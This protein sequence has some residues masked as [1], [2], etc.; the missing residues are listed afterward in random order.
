MTPIPPAV[1]DPRLTTSSPATPATRPLPAARARGGRSM[2]PSL[3][4]LAANLV[5]AGLLVF[6]PSRSHAGR[7]SAGAASGPFA[8]LLRE[9]GERRRSTHPE[10]PT[11]P[12]E[13]TTSGLTLRGLGRALTGLLPSSAAEAEAMTQ[14]ALGPLPAS[15]V[16]GTFFDDLLADRDSSLA[17]WPTNATITIWVQPDPAVIDWTPEYALQVTSAVAQWRSAGLPLVFQMTTDSAAANVHIVFAHSIPPLRHHALT[18]LTRWTSD[19]DGWITDA[20][21]TLGVHRTP[22]EPKLE[23]QAMRT[24]ALHEFGH[25]LGLDHTRMVGSIMRPTIPVQTLSPADIATVRLLYTR[26]PGP[27]FPTAGGEVVITGE[28]AR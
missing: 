28:R 11:S 12:M 18:G 4:L 26:L 24:I 14:G 8:A 6:L 15:M 19:A 21:V 3:T 27:Q 22:R 20:H 17:R 5:V 9:P 7:P 16:A 23:I 10:G 1:R 13:P 25:L 2:T